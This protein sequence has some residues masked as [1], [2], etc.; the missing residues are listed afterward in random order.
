MTDKFKYMLDDASKEIDKGLILDP[1]HAFGYAAKLQ[2]EFYNNNWEE[3]FNVAEKAYKLAG[4]RPHLL[5][6]IGYSLAYGG[7]CEKED[8][9]ASTEKFQ[10]VKKNRC[11]FQ[12]GCWEIG[13]KAY[14][15][16]I[17]N[18]ATWDNYLLAQCYQTSGEKENVIRVLEPLQHKNFVW[19]NLHLGLAYDS[20]KK[21]DIAKKHLDF[22]KKFL[23]ENHLSKIKFA[24][25]KQNQHLNTYPYITNNLKKYGFE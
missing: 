1:E 3:M 16:D 14:E 23:K 10:I 19:W 9:F 11:Q 21:F 18:Y 8:V 20:L 7:E 24:L 25:T 4:D 17:G 5:G 13:K 15:L 6:K 2:I 22:V 12:R